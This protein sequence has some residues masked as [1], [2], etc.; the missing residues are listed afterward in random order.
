VWVA[1]ILP[2]ELAPTTAEMMERGLAAIKRT[3]EGGSRNLEA[4]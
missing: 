4:A 2:D 3:L 1:D